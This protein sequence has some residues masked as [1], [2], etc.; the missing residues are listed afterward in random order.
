MIL[1]NFI[2]KIFDQIKMIFF[3]GLLL[4]LPISFTL[5]IFTYSFT[6]I[7]RWIEPLNKFV[8]EFLREVPYSEFLL[9]I[10]AIFIAGVLVRSFVLEPLVSSIE[11]IFFKIP[12]MNPIYS[13]VKQ[14]VRAFTIQDTVSFQQVVLVQFPRPGIYSIGF[15]TKDIHL[16]LNN[17]PKELHSVFIPT[18]P[19]PTSGYLI[20]VP[21]EEFTIIDITRQEAMS[22]II[23]GGIVQPERFKNN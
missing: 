15:L 5:W 14:L 3:H 2:H 11:A 17:E 4:L 19:N 9:V 10:A 16:N 21:Q 1:K 20:L 8:P 12:L 13:G 22:L 6:L 18:T 7:A 23:S